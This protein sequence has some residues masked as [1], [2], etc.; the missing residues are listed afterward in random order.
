VS[1]NLSKLQK[2]EYIRVVRT[3]RGIRIAVNKAKKT[4][5]KDRGNL[6]EK[7]EDN[8]KFRE[9]RFSTNAMR[10]SVSAKSN[11]RQLRQRTVNKF[12]SNA[13]SDFKNLEPINAEGRQKLHALKQ[14]LLIKTI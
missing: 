4:F 14:K 6:V 3:P 2:E 5:K 7:S 13:D 10:F 12:T 11:I 1:R 8:S 9:K